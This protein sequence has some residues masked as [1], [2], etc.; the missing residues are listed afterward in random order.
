[1]LGKTSPNVLGKTAPN[2]LVIITPNVLGIIAPSLRHVCICTV[3]HQNVR[4]LHCCTHFILLVLL[5]H[6]CVLHVYAADFGSNTCNFNCCTSLLLYCMWI[7]LL[8]TFNHTS[9]FCAANLDSKICNLCASPACCSIAGGCPRLLHLQQTHRS[10]GPTFDGPRHHN[11]Q[12][13]ESPSDLH[14]F[15][16]H[17]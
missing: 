3:R 10:G 7:P 6:P 4:A 17:A 15:T 14:A 11:L 2:V 12:V 5:T 9:H 1:M 13:R 8:T 16:F